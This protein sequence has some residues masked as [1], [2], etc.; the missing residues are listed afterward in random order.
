MTIKASKRP[1]FNRSINRGVRIGFKLKHARL[2]KGLRLHELAKR[3][4]CTEGFLSKVENDKVNPS[5]AVLHRLVRELE[6]NI[7]ILFDPPTE[8]GPVQIMLPGKRPLIKLDPMLP[9]RGIA[10]ERLIST[11]R[12]MLLEA[13]IH[14]VDPGGRTDGAITHEGEELGYVLE[15]QLELEVDGRKY[16]L[17]KGDSFFYRSEL[18]HQYRNPGRTSTRVLWVCTPPTF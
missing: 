6:V 8:E 10:L 17:S 1:S 11:G 3:L 7:A 5:L 12:G 16:R 13:N 15:G 9:G 2:T 4:G 18:K 14:H